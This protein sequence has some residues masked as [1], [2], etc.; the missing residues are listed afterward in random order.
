MPQRAEGDKDP[1]GGISY[2]GQKWMDKRNKVQ[3][4]IEIRK[5]LPY[6]PTSWSEPNADVLVGIAYSNQYQNH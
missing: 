3:T 4:Y 6:Q 1:T 5:A 2:L